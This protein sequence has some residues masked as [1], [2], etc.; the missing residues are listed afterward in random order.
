MMDD[1]TQTFIEEAKDLLENMEQA[2]LSMEDNPG[3]ERHVNAIFRAAHT[4]KGTAG[5]FSFDYVE[6]FTHVVESVLD[7]VRKGELGID[8]ELIAL[9]LQAGDHIGSLVEA[10]AV[11]Q[12]DPDALLLQE[13]EKITNVLGGYLDSGQE[14]VS[15]PDTVKTEDADTLEK[16]DYD[17]PVA[18]RNWH[19]SLHFSPEVL[20]HGMDPL[21][22]LRY[23]QKLGEIVNT[24]TISDALPGY[25]G[26]D[27][28]TC[29]LAFEIEF[30]SEASK[31]QI[32]QVFEFVAELCAIRILP[33]QAKLSEYAAFI[34]SIK[35]VDLM[36]GEMLVS[37]GALT[38]R[39][40][41]QALQKQDHRSSEPT[42]KIGEVLVEDKVVQQEIV[43]V[44]AEKQEAMRGKVA[45]GSRA[46]RVDADKLDKLINLVG[47]LVIS[48]AT[49]N[50]LAAQTGN[51]SLL[52]SISQMSRLVEEIRDSALTLRM[53]QIGETFNRFKRVVR[54]VSKELGKDI[55]LEINGGETELDKTV[56]EKIGDPL[57]HIVRNAMDHGIETAS[58]REKNA[59]TAYGTLV[60][61]AF[62]ES[63]SIVIEVEDDGK[64]LDKKKILAKAHE[65]NLVSEGQVVTDNEIYKLVFEAGFSTASEV[66]NLSGRGVGMD[67]VKRN[68]EALRGTIEI[69][70]DEGIGTRIT[71][72]LP[73]T[74]AIIDGFMV[75][76]GD[77]CYVIPLDM[78]L[79]CIEMDSEVSEYKQQ[80][81]YINLRGEVLPCI[82]LSEMFKEDKK[83]DARRNIVVVEFAGDKVGIVVDELL[84]EFQTV[85]KP[86]GKV[87]QNLSGVSGATILGSGDVAVILDIPS[88]VQRM[89]QRS[90][91]P[92]QSGGVAVNTMH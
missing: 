36:I 32:E 16:V 4:L 47:E 90:V 82:Q 77:S 24:T 60:L 34:Q 83:P 28:E 22:F 21:S 92:G 18:S 84:G 78:V 70:S 31:E 67:V 85:I 27:P 48:G 76:V 87:L 54:D 11:L 62:H 14:I 74:M 6:R 52:E 1:A 9:L 33:P 61:N 20:R 13:G 26:L 25:K 68:I 29:Y 86:M 65:R 73:L 8:S 69:S 35:E 15:I 17:R 51:E 23:L 5:V 53:V 72:R 59:K 71:I 81:G 46:L 58:E 49:T 88:I 42:K 44:A 3:E 7:N 75:G 50:L 55:R 2:L 66:T 56:I 64:G 37:S 45:G 41:Q 79:E 43:E 10:A 38:R 91:Q 89:V 63:G 30:N 19:I 80:Q 57:M 40:L 12:Q 39:E